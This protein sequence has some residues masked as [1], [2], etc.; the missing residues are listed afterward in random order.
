MGKW[1]A[2]ELFTETRKTCKLSHT[3]LGLLSDM[4]YDI[5]AVRDIP[6][7]EKDF[8]SDQCGAMFRNTMLAG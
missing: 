5:W 4:C 8:I 7:D 6:Q 2:K 3:R 1:R